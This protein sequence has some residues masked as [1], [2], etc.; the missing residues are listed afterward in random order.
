MMFVPGSSV[1]V[2]CFEIIVAA[3]LIAM[4]AITRHAYRSDRDLARK[5]TMRVFLG[6]LIWLGVLLA[7]IK[8]DQLQAL[9]L[10]GMPVFFGSILLVSVAAGLSPFGARLAAH[11]P[12]AA[13]IAFQAFRLPLELILHRWAQRG[14]IPPT[15]TWTG[16]NWDIV[17]GALAFVIWPIAKNRAVAWGFNII[18]AILL[19]NVL[20]VALLSS[21]VPFGWDTQPP[22]QL[23]LHAPYFLIGPVLVGSA[24]TGHIVLTRALLKKAV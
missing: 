2:L 13:L 19:L 3:V 15:M 6:Y 20:R 1:S 9:P 22:L 11:T 14:T 21:P 12:I 10:Q 18:G 8:T 5:V 23:F 7:L 17:A 16:Q 24:I 4:I